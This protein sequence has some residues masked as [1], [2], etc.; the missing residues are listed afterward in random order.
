MVFTQDQQ[1]KIHLLETKLSNLLQRMD[2][3]LHLEGAMP[4]KHRF[5]LFIH[6]SNGIV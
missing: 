3:P 5:F 2:A 4:T 6:F 1:V